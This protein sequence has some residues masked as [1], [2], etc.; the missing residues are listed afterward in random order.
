MNEIITVIGYRKGQVIA[1]D[2]S[3]TMRRLFNALRGS[4]FETTGSFI[5][6]SADDPVTGDQLLFE[7]QDSRSVR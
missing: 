4:G 7:V 2:T 6:F 5:R 3:T 1:E